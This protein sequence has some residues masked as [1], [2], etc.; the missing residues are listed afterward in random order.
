MNPITGSFITIDEMSMIWV[1][2]KQGVMSLSTMEAEFT[3]AFIIT[4]YS[5]YVRELLQELSL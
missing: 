2:K 1:C 3:D 5:W 4:R